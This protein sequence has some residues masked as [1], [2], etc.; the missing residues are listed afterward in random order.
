MDHPAVLPQCL[1]RKPY[2]YLTNASH[3]YSISNA[4][5][6]ANGDTHIAFADPHIDTAHASYGH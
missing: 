5:P 2:G 6:D 4:A 1:I 3:A